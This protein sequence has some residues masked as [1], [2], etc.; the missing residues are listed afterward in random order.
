MTDETVAGPK[1]SP[2][3]DV[4]ILRCALACFVIALFCMLSSLVGPPIAMAAHMPLEA[5]FT[6]WGV[7]VAAMA[8]VL[9][10]ILIRSS[11]SGTARV[12]RQ[13][14]PEEADKYLGPAL[15]SSKDPIGDWRKLA[16][17]AGFTGVFLKL[18]LSGMPLATILMTFLFCILSITAPLLNFPDAGNHVH[19][20]QATLATAF[21]DM[22]KLT[23]GAFIGSFVTKGTTRDTEAG[24]AGAAAALTQLS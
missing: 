23:L 17:L 22:A 5:S 16:G 19:F 11:R 7:G 1:N 10:L 14:L 24:K 21:L 15:L 2:S 4:G 12:V 8:A 20:D 3:D 6:E 18:D 9:G 13:V